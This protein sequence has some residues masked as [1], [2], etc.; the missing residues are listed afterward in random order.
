[1]RKDNNLD[2]IEHTFRASFHFSQVEIF[3]ATGAVAPNRRTD[4]VQLGFRAL[5][6]A[7][8]ANYLSAAIVGFFMR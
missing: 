2:H 7:T 4:L 8:L 6:G 1:V 3:G 5:L